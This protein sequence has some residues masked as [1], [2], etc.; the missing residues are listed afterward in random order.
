[1][2]KIKPQFLQVCKIPALFIYF[3]RTW[4]WT[5]TVLNQT[6][7]QDPRPLKYRSWSEHRPPQI[8]K[9]NPG[10]VT[11]WA[12]RHIWWTNGFRLVLLEP[13]AF[14]RLHALY[15]CLCFKVNLN[16]STNNASLNPAQSGPWCDQAPKS[17]GTLPDLQVLFPVKI[18]TFQEAPKKQIIKNKYVSSLHLRFF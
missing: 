8:S 1:M 15:N 3:C 6:A 4:G 10:L 18:R 9:L 7:L 11:A 5:Q 12:T 14:I 13:E 16:K 17:G 2:D